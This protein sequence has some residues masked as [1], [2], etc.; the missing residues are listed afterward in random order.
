[1]TLGKTY[2]AIQH[3]YIDI[4]IALRLIHSRLTSIENMDQD[5]TYIIQRSLNNFQKCV[6]IRYKRISILKAFSKLLDFCQQNHQIPKHQL[7][8]RLLWEFLFCGY[9]FKST[10][11]TKNCLRKLNVFYMKN[12]IHGIRIRKDS[13]ISALQL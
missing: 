5:T 11:V 6:K 3:H 8:I 12:L 13:N 9:D 1:M 10:L 7:R 4:N 2:T